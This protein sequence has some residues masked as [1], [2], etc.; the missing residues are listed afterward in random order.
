MDCGTSNTA[1]RH[2]EHCALNENADNNLWTTRP[3]F[4][5][6]HQKRWLRLVQNYLNETKGIDKKAVIDACAPVL[7]THGIDVDQLAI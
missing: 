2:V 6:C 3:L 7:Q 1:H 5:R 4:D